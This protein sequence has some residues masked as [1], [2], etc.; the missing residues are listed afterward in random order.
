MVSSSNE[1]FYFKNNTINFSARF[2]K[3]TPITKIV[4]YELDSLLIFRNSRLSGLEEDF[5]WSSF[6]YCEELWRNLLIALKKWIWPSTISISFGK[7]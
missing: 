5:V 1:L 3:S 7:W 2:G 4:E 6:V